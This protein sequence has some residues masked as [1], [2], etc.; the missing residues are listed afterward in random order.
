MMLQRVFL[1]NITKSWY[2]YIILQRVNISIYSYRGL[3]YFYIFLQRVGIW[4]SSQMDVK[5]DG[6][7]HS[8]VNCI[9]TVQNL[10]ECS[11]LAVRLSIEDSVPQV[12]L[13]VLNVEKYSATVLLAAGKYS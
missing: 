5:S 13:S 4:Q 10:C 1:Y 8:F 11:A 9:Y 2:F 6:Y 7:L 12:L 3:I